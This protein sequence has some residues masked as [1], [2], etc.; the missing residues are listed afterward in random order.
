M[1]VVKNVLREPQVRT[2][3]QYRRHVLYLGCIYVTMFVSSVCGIVILT[4]HY[5]LFVTLTQRSN[6]ETLTIAFLLI[7]FL[8]LS[9]VSFKGATASLRILW[10]RALS[11]WM[12]PLDL[13]RRKVR[14][15]G[16]PGES[17]PPAV[18][19][20]FLI[21][22]EGHPNEPFQFK[23]EDAAGSMGVICVEGALLVH[24]GAYRDGTYSLFPFLVY[25]IGGVL[26][27]RNIVHR[28]DIVE[29]LAIADESLEQ[30]IGM[31]RF[32]SNL[33]RH[34][35]NVELWPKLV[36]TH[37]E[38]RRIEGELSKICATLR[39]ESFFPHWEY[40]GDHKLPIIPE[41]LGIISLSRGE[42]RV[43]P[44][45]SMGAAAVMALLCFMIAL[46]MV[47]FRPW[48]PGL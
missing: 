11:L 34:L 3:H 41:P 7:F 32:A 42:K 30:Y 4:R 43:D 25:Q 19:L 13:E 39:D 28:L 37:G 40:G 29:W 15:L 21:E 27:S 44:I 10:Y 24:D 36:L 33:S 22:R 8:Y 6:V 12:D 38:C 17:E 23:L 16:P 2:A 20:N 48:V 9:A 47:C 45:S 26:K 14:A 46:W 1:D 18:A 35:G 31:T 5:K